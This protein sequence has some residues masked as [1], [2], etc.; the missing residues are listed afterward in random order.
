[1]AHLFS[2][3][4]PAGRPSRL[5][6]AREAA[7]RQRASE[8]VAADGARW[9]ALQVDVTRILSASPDRDGVDAAATDV[10]TAIARA[11]DWPLGR[12]LSAD[13]E[14]EAEARGT[15]P[16]SAQSAEA[17]PARHLRQALALGERSFGSFAFDTGGGPADR[18]ALDTMSA[19]AAQ[20]AQFLARCHAE[21][22]LRCERASLAARVVERTTELTETN[23]RLDT[24]RLDAENA[25]RAKSAFLATMSHEIRTPMN[26]VIGMV[27]VL[28]ESP[29]GEDQADAVRTIRASAFSLLGLIDDIL[30]FSKIEAG[31][32]DLEH[33]PVDLTELVEGIR[34][35]FGIDAAARGVDLRI[36]IAPEVPEQVRS[37]ATRLRQMLSNLVGNAVKFSGGRPQQPGVVSLR[38]ELADTAPLRLRMSVT[39]NGIGIDAAMLGSLFTSFTQAETTTTRRF[40]GSG[41][42]LAICKRLVELMG[43]SIQVRSEP[44][45]GSTFTITLPIEA[46]GSALRRDELAGLDCIVVA[47]PAIDADDLGVYL[48]HAGARVS[49]A[50]GGRSAA[51]IAT[52]LG[53]GAVVVI[54]HCGAG[55]GAAQ[56]ARAPFGTRANVRHV[57]IASARL[58]NAD[59]IIPGVVVLET[60]LLRR[61]SLLRA[62]AAAGGRMVAPEPKAVRLPPPR[63]GRS[64]APT[65]TQGT[66]P[67]PA[68][69]GG[70]GRRGEPEGHPQAAR[71]AR[72]RGRGGGQRR[73]GPAPLAR[74]RPCA[75]AERPAHA[76]ARRLRPGPCDPRC[77][78]TAAG[79]AT[80]ADPRPDRQR[81]ARRSPARA[82]RRHGPVPH[83][84]DPAAGARRRAR[85]LDA[86]DRHRSRCPDGCGGRDAVDTVSARHA[87]VDVSVLKGLVGD[88]MATVCDFLAQFLD[89]A[90]AQA[91]EISASCVREDNR[92]VGAVAHKLKASSRS[93][94]ALALGDL[95]AE[96]ENVS[97]AGSKAELAEGC[98]R[99]ESEL[100]DVQDCIRGVLAETS[101]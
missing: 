33:A 8:G 61:S 76:G 95:C 68:H 99:F 66:R 43:G 15:A 93:V 53:D 28:A 62:V 86:E 98:A 51:R 36:F 101:S 37:D 82:R 19:I 67:E 70:R 91:A 77:G 23:R 26:G 50:P 88:D 4:K 57:L 47:H 45:V 9:R 100:R 59:M 41:L 20:T 81:T 21:A 89:S 11:A 22:E 72:P 35:V 46:I 42:G 39:D 49:Q 34:D 55:S 14:A 32:L 6:T 24:A 12:Y 17:L 56:V 85:S 78:V 40:G 71:A 74:G 7:L 16:A 31:H 2:H 1:M 96:L 30:D 80:A 25:N 44:Q 94:G 73:R 75:A 65:I 64:L 84:A 79:A 18:G 97:V 83:Q 69:P 3:R 90:R 87:A 10:A 5:R 54:Q 13:A 27:E 92:R 58:R 48:E 29:L 60:A 63:A 52:R 38:I